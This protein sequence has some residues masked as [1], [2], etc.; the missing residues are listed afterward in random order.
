MAEDRN[1]LDVT[2]IRDAAAQLRV[3]RAW[4]RVI[5]IK[6]GI[7]LARGFGRNRRHIRVSVTELREAILNERVQSSVKQKQRRSTRPA[8]SGIDPL[9]TC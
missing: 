5:A 6:H 7:A 4:A 8:D 2:T 1:I 9:V 3:G